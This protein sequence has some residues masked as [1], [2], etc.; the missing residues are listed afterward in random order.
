M[1]SPEVIGL[2][3][4]SRHN[5]STIRPERI[6]TKRYALAAEQYSYLLNHSRHFS[7]KSKAL[8]AENLRLR[9]RVNELEWEIFDHVSE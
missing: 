1:L 9:A 6:N 5:A 3:G 4:P 2:I 8:A 7:Q